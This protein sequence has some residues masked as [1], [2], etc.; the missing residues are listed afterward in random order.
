M[1][2]N[3]KMKKSGLKILICLF[4]VLLAL[5]LICLYFSK[6]KNNSE[7]SF[8]EES[9]EIEKRETN[10]TEEITEEEF[11]KSPLENS[12]K[13]I[14]KKPFGIY[15]TP[16]NSPV[17][18]EKFSGYHTGTDFEILN[19]ES[20]KEVPVF[21]ICNGKILEKKI[22]SGYGGV[23]VQEGTIN[24]QQ[25]TVLYSHILYDTNVSVG[26]FFSAGVQIG[27]LADDKSEYS[28]G[29]RKHLHVGVHKGGEIDYRGY[30]ENQED[31]SDWLNIEK[32]FK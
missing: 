12:E 18:P 13:R 1:N 2:K 8:V 3:L 9:S 22:V 27:V 30:V 26:D 25:V 32:Y 24:S 20:S 19:D 15:I 14:T 11:L 23:I 7:E 16:E 4:F 5:L 21:A 10:Q 17:Q 28:G 29:E 6:E 31:L